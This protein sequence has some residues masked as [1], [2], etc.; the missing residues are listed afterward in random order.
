MT[1]R[2]LMSEDEARLTAK[3][4]ATRARIVQAA[5][6]LMF[7][8]GVAGTSTEDVR[9]SAGVSNS[10]L[11]HYFNDKNRLVRAVIVH[12]TQQVLDAQ[13]PLLGRLDSF[14]AL[15]AWRDLL[16]DLQ[17][18]RDCRGGCPIGSLAGELADADEEARKL[19]V[20]GFARWES[21]IRDGLA[22]MR[23]RGE[24]RPD[25]DP[26]QLALVALTALQGGLLLTETRRDVAPLRAGLNAAIAYIRSHAA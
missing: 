19:L 3:G 2:P 24:L 16:I 21:A 4:R 8:R 12:Q 15:E 14:G 26:D 10:Q 13:Q 22:S 7:E 9:E 17:Q 18:Q 5:A 25:A 11:Y 20:T 23:D 1:Q 6:D